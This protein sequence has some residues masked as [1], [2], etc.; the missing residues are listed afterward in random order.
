M[1]FENFFSDACSRNY[2]FRTPFIVY[3]V[4]RRTFS[5]V[6]VFLSN[7]RVL[8]RVGL[9]L[10]NLIA[11]IIFNRHMGFMIRVVVVVLKIYL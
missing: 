6:V 4:V 2:P 7:V 8:V 3:I 9:N 1:P 11:S 10:Q 5:N